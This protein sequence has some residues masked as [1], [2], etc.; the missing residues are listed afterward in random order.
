M[1]HLLYLMPF[2]ASR[3]SNR[4]LEF[5]LTFAVGNNIQPVTIPTI[6]GDSFFVRGEQHISSR[7]TQPFNLNEA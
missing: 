5:W 1:I 7:F 4:I 3:V 2:E 6:L